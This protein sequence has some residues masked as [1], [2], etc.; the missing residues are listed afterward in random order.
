MVFLEMAILS[1]QSKQRNISRYNF[2]DD[3]QMVMGWIEKLVEY[4]DEEEDTLCVEGLVDRSQVNRIR[5]VLGME[6]L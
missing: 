1:N 5:A 4:V 3:M 2:K 6:P